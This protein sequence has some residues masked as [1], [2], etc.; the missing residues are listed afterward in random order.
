MSSGRWMRQLDLAYSKEVEELPEIVG[1]LS[2]DLA[3][4]FKIIE[5][6]LKNPQTDHWER[7]FQIFN[8]LL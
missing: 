6:G 8:L 4:T 5:P 2:I 1:G 3:N 7:A